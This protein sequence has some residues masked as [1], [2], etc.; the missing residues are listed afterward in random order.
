M[1]RLF[2]VGGISQGMGND[3][4][5]RLG[6]A[7]EELISPGMAKRR[8]ARSMV[9]HLSRSIPWEGFQECAP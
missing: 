7:R 5:R 2:R 8:A 3:K 1:R 6:A 4:Y 9:V